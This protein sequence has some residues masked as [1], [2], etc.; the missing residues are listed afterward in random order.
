M[1]HSTSSFNSDRPNNMMKPA[2]STLL[3]ALGVLTKMSAETAGVV[4][5]RYLEGSFCDFGTITDVF[6]SIVSGGTEQVVESISCTSV[7]DE[8]LTGQFP[9]VLPLL[10]NLET[11]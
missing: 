6:E 9:T 8:E 2:C 7:R 5:S 1:R 3:V 10:P 11:L 4:S